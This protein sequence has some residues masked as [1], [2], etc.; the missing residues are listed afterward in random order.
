MPSVEK[1]AFWA[2]G[3]VQL[4]L[5]HS[6]GMFE[7]GLTGGSIVPMYIAAAI[8]LSSSA[9]PGLPRNPPSV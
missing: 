8:I 1:V 6:N 9:K 3:K 7:E 5:E 4:P 2:A